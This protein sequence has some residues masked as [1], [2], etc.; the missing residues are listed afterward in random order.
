MI[1]FGQPVYAVVTNKKDLSV[2]MYACIAHI[3]T[4]HTVSLVT[5]VRLRYLLTWDKLCCIWLKVL[6]KKSII[7]LGC[8]MAALF[9]SSLATCKPWS[10]ACRNVTRSLLPDNSGW[11]AT[12]TRKFSKARR[13]VSTKLD[14]KGGIDRRTRRDQ[15]ESASQTRRRWQDE[16]APQRLVSYCF[17]SY[18]LKSTNQRFL[19]YRRHQGTGI[20]SNQL[21]V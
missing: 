3:P 7:F 9:A 6:L 15:R 8:G 11:W 5:M 12:R 17:V 21:V 16:A 18:L 19:R 1:R 20:G 10:S 2:I 13:R 14:L 4:G